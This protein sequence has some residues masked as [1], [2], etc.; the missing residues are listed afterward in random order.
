M[1]TWMLPWKN[2]TTSSNG[3]DGNKTWHRRHS[4]LREETR[5]IRYS[6]EAMKMTLVVRNTQQGRCIGGGKLLISGRGRHH[7]LRHHRPFAAHPRSA[8]IGR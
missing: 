8:T 6:H 3:H 2:W 4:S 7:Q 1:E 5:T